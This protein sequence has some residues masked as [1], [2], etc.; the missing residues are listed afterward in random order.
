[1]KN[2]IF[3]LA[4]LMAIIF[5]LFCGAF[6]VSAGEI[7]WEEVGSFSFKSMKVGTTSEKDG[8]YANISSRLFDRVGLKGTGKVEIMKEGDDVFA[9][10]TATASKKFVTLSCL[11][12]ENL[13]IS[14]YKVTFTYRFSEGMT[15]TDANR[16]FVVRIWDGNSSHTHDKQ[17]VT[18]GT[19][20]SAYTEWRTATV[21]IETKY[22]SS[23]LWFFVYTEAGEY[24]DVKD[25]SISKLADPKFPETV[26]YDASKNND[27]VINSDLCGHVL[28]KIDDW[29]NPADVKVLD[30]ANYVIGEDGKGI[31]FKREFMQTL[32]AGEKSFA[33]NV[34]GLD[35]IVVVKVY[36]SSVVDPPVKAGVIKTE[37]QEPTT[38]PT[39]PTEN[40]NNTALIAIIAGAAVVVAA[41]AVVITVIAV[42]KKKK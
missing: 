32:K 28:D 3:A 20:L 16:G 25:I 8:A 37:A 2:R 9:R 33:F 15:F 22:N 34:E 6:T 14:T 29:S 21:E 35:Y 30:T 26:N 17:A 1:M 24:F 7:P 19:D 39:E 4:S 23:S 11:P 18:K 40:N 31:T 42:K 41:A 13:P 12:R 5:T 27:L 36:N 10:A 38:E